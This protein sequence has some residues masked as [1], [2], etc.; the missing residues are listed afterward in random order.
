MSTGARSQ[1]STSTKDELLSVDQITHELKISRRTFYRW[2]ELHIA[3]PSLRL[4]NGE[5]RVFRSA[6]AEW[7]EHLGEQVA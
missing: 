5:I 1:P 6:L 3:P 2:R 4:P 7:L